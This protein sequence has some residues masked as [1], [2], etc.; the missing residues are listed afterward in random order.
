MPGNTA[1]HRF[2]WVLKNTLN[3]VTIAV[4]RSSVGPFSTICHV[5]RTSGRAYKTPVILVKL[6]EGFIVELTYGENVDWYRNVKAAGGCLV[7]HHGKTYRINRIEPCTAEEGRRAY[8]APFR[9]ILKATGRREFRILR[10][11]S[12]QA[13]D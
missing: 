13:A 5:G 9:Q 12:W 2:F 1:R 4:S 7:V 8:P 6:P 3:R 10:T 11:D